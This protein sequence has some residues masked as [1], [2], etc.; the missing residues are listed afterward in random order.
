MEFHRDIIPGTLPAKE[1]FTSLTAQQK[2]QALAHKYYSGILWEPK[3]GDYYTTSR[4]DLELYQ[5]VYAD[6]TVVKTKYCIGSDVVSEWPTYTFLKD[7]GEKR[8]FVPEWI[9]KLDESISPIDR[10]GEERKKLL[11]KK[12]NALRLEVDSS[13]VDDIKKTVDEIFGTNI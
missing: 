12:L 10:Q 13:I 6:E 11:Y 3:A 1:D 9:F 4:A 2:L 5:V 7:F 8:V